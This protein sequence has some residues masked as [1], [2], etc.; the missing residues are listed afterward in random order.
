MVGSCITVANQPEP[1]AVWHG[2]PPAA[3]GTDLAA[4]ATA[5][6]A[7]SATHA[8]AMTAT[9]GAADAKAVAE[10]T[11]ENAAYA[12][13]RAMANHF[14]KTGDLDRRGKV[15]FSKSEIVRLR[16]LDLRDQAT[17]IRDLALA[18]TTQPGAA[19]RGITPARIGELTAAITLFSTILST[20]RGQIVT[21]ATLLKEVETDTAALLENLRDLDDLVVQFAATPAG[22]RFVQAWQNARII[23]DAGHGP[24]TPDEEDPTPP[25]P[26]PPAP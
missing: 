17:A 6:A 2:Q 7:V 25:A 19:D 13:A 8:L 24:G 1:K 9:G 11:L 21:R 12:M 10:A 4:L 15:D 3:F 5:H 26:T 20:P 23:V 22:Q 18:A 14:K 16:N